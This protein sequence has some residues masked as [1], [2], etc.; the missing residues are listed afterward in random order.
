M[1]I[2]DLP[3]GYLNR[4]SVLGEHRELHGIYA[5]LTNG[6]AGYARHPETQR[7]AKALSGLALRHRQLAEEM[8][9]R[10][11]VDR[12]PLRCVPSKLAIRQRE[13]FLL[14]SVALSEL[15]VF[16]DVEK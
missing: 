7:W 10:G 3:A 4:Q 13:P 2:W 15:A 1:R 6:K 16:I 5:I 9:L 12:T 11:Y 14:Y 8:R